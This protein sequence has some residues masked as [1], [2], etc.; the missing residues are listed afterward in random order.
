MPLGKQVTTLRPF[1][2]LALPR[3]RTAWLSRLLTYGDWVCG[4]EE[5]RHCRS[6]DDVRAWFSQ[7]NVG[8]VETAVAPFWRLIDKIAPD[9]NLV[10]IRRP[11]DEVVE[12]LMAVP[13]CNFDGA[14]LT[15]TIRKLDRKLDQFERRA[16][17]LSVPY[18]DLRRAEVCRMI[19]RKCLP[20]EWDY[21]HW[22]RLSGEN[23]QCDLRAMMRYAEA[24]RPALEKLA[25]IAKHRML[26]DMHLH[27][28]STAG[29]TY[30]VEDF[31]DWLRDAT[32]LFDEH[33][34][35]VG[36]A[37]GDHRHKNITLMRKL[38]EIGAMQIMTARANGRMF[39]YLM[40]IIAPSLEAEGRVVAA[41]TTFFASP[42]APGLGIKLQRAALL[43]LKDRSVN[44]VA[45]QAGARGAGPR[46]GTIFKR[47]GAQEDGQVFRLQLAEA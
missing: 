35:Q 29:M 14:H 28:P 6:I 8:S 37:P 22:E 20:Y 30:Q 24:Y 31:D 33:L 42:D 43:S 47:L 5:A 45:M 27:P 25:S 2:I 41:H 4:H 36:E 21:Y 34:V 7:R 16:G 38:H 9:T 39:G 18:K 10:T 44:E 17:A 13:G 1:L 3:S 19:F 23:I 26:T 15:D 46:M 32:P 12:S 40:S 11:V